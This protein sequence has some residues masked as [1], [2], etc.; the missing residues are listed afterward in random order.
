MKKIILLLLAAILAK[1]SFAQITTSEIKVEATNNLN[2]VQGRMGIRI[3]A[4][5][6]L[7]TETL[8]V[9][10]AISTEE[11]VVNITNLS[12]QDFIVRLSSSGAATKRTIIGPSV[13]NRFSLGVGLGSSN[14]NEYLTIVDG[15]NVGIGLTNPTARMHISSGGLPL[16]INSN[17]NINP[18]TSTALFL[19]QNGPGGNYNQLNSKI[20]FSPDGTSH[21][22]SLG[23][24]GVTRD[25]GTTPHRSRLQL[26]SD[27][28][29]NVLSLDLDLQRVGIG[30]TYS[31]S[32]TL[33]VNGSAYCSSGNWSG[34]DVRFKKNIE[35][36]VNS[37]DRVV[38]LRG[39]SFDW[40]HDEFED[41]SF[42]TQRE[43]GFIAQEVEQIAPEVIHTSEDGYK[44]VAYEKLTALLAE[45]IEE[46]KREKDAEIAEL[47]REKNAQIAELKQ[48]LSAMQ[49][50]WAEL[51]AR[52]ALSGDNRS[53]SQPNEARRPVDNSN[54]SLSTSSSEITNNQNQRK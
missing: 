53:S 37:L 41:R 43:I 26:G 3:D 2:S 44:A 8:R 51:E 40:R 30:G 13:P 48:E 19:H 23:V 6:T 35:P 46:V 4:K 16:K 17:D 10:G 14:N 7:P 52:L 5:P 50:G 20:V 54:A 9:E 18:P 39:V 22:G 12:D 15:G 38:Q 21:P 24:I 42:S 49:Q 47:R 25:I 32:Y 1:V 45:A 11:N 31:P 33:H 34:S 28:K 27:T 36:L 29:P